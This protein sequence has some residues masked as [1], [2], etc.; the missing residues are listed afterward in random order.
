MLAGW[1]TQRVPGNSVFLPIY[2]A[3]CISSIWLLWVVSFYNKL[4]IQLV[5]CF[6]GF[7][8][9]FQ[10]I[11]ELKKGVTGTSNLRFFVRSTRSPE[12]WLAFKVGGRLVG[13]RPYLLYLTLTPHKE[14]Q[15]WTVGY[16]ASVEELVNVEKPYTVGVRNTEG[17]K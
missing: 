11:I 8:E 5:N 10:Q 7:C 12:L 17:R 6:P 3:L 2:L 9:W 4:V 13:L 1:G 16:S 15:Y 14:H